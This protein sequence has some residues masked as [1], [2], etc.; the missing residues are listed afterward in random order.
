MDRFAND[1]RLAVRRVLRAPAFATIAILTLALGIGANTAIFTLVRAVLLRPL[2]YG[3]PGR[4]VMLWRQDANNIETTWLSAPEVASYAREVPAFSAVAAYSATAANLTGGQEPERVIAAAVS[5][6]LFAT[7][8]V[9]AVAG[10]AFLP[11]DSA[12]AIADQVVLGHALWTRRFGARSDIIGQSIEVNGTARTVIGVMPPSFRLP[13]D[14]ADDRPSEL[15]LPLDLSAPGLAAWG[16]HGLLGFARLHDGADVGVATASMRVL[17]ER[18]FTEGHWSNRDLGNRSAVPVQRLVLGEIRYAL[19]VLFGAVGVI[20]LIACANVAN[21][22]L[23]RSDERHRELAVRAALG[24]SRQ[25]ILRQLVTESV[26]LAVIG[27]L[28]GTGLAYAGVRALVAASPAG[29]PRIDAAGVDGGVLLF[30]LVLTIA[31]GVVF[32]LAP[33]L[34]FS[35]PDVNRA[36]KEGGRT[37]TVGRSRQ[38]FRDML[39][40][41]QMAFSVV[42]L[43][44][45]MLLVRSFNELR[46][47]DLGFRTNDALTLR[48]VLPSSAYPQPANVIESYRTLRLSFASLPG[49]VAVGATRLLPLTGTIGDW[50]ITLEGRPRAPGENPNGDW[51]VV[52]PGY[53][54]S[55]GIPVRGR[56]INDG[57]H[58]NAP[59][60]AV[61]NE[62]MA[63]RYWPNEDAIGKRFHLGSNARPWLTI[64]G[65]ARRVRHNA[66][67]ETPRAEMYLPHAQF[68]AAGGSAQRGLTFVL[69]TNGDPLALLPH[70]RNAVRA[71]DPNLP[72]ADVRTLES[73]ADESVAQQRFTTLLLGLFAALAL[74]LATIGIYGV[75]S[76]LVSRRRQ[77]IGIRIALGA[78]RTVI[79]GM[80]IRRGMALAGLGVMGG[81]AAAAVLSRVVANML[82]GVSAY[83][84]MTFVVV[85]AILAVVAFVACLI[86]ATR[87]AGVQPVVALREE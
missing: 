2:P 1:V 56:V 81:L 3:E 52:M 70:V 74:T 27:G 42:L 62:T 14:F 85:P 19:W 17:E 64:V 38:R 79:L 20:L 4:L 51:Q 72:L 7:L 45:A 57:D 63:Q 28:V 9:T 80:V 68:A 10:R 82:Y 36:L 49:V 76:L 46:R 5:P 15:W 29:I 35:R 59:L 25:R 71:F 41:S 6:N 54:E 16:N 12:A 21:L 23:A 73:V 31:T 50:S 33:A 18:W 58:E 84:P 34:E 8:R 78:R 32:G 44:G 75:I 26:V 60:V 55:M 67:T 22:T 66:V 69:R 47:V 39:A 86:P 53:F 11:S 65:I 24:A 30:T 37:G 61:V 48:T 40:V 83:D 13:L 77:E 87:A 43:I